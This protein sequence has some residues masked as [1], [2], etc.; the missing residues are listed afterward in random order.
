MASTW[1]FSRFDW[2]RWFH[3]ASWLV[4][5]FIM[6]RQTCLLH[7]YLSHDGQKKRWK[8]GQLG[9]YGRSRCM[10]LSRRTTSESGLLYQR[11]CGD[12]HAQWQSCFWN[13]KIRFCYWRI[14][15][16]H[17]LSSRYAKGRRNQESCILWN[18]NKWSPIRLAH[19]IRQESAKRQWW[20]GSSH[21]RNRRWRRQRGKT[22]RQRHHM[23]G[24]RS[25]KVVG[26]GKQ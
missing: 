12:A 2:L 22:W 9:F 6:E 19:T 5:G 23:Y 10:E 21:Y 15:L 3:Q 11:T 25:R 4:S 7:R 20:S 14:L 1:F 24:D 13:R 26:F 16:G 8:K 18:Q 17:S